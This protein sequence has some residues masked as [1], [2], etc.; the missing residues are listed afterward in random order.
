MGHRAILPLSLLV[1]SVQ[2]SGLLPLPKPPLQFHSNLVFSSSSSDSTTPS[3]ALPKD[4]ISFNTDNGGD[5]PRYPPPVDWFGGEGW[6]GDDEEAD[7][8]LQQLVMEASST[9][10][11]AADDLF[12]QM[13]RG[14]S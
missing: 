2:T 13:S 11:K 4:G 12:T 6:G 5:G 9:T 7:E 14:D 10:K 3:G 1:L 8:E